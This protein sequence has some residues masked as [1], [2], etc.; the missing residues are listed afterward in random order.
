MSEYKPTFFDRHGPD[1]KHHLVAFGYGFMIFGLVAGVLMLEAGLHW[2]VFPVALAAGFAGGGL[3]LMLGT[4]TGR[5]WEHFMMSGASTPYVEQYSY[6]QALVMK[7]QVDEALASFEHVIAARP[8]AVGARIKAAELYL[9]ERRNPE[10]A[11]QLFREAQRTPSITSG[12]DVYV[13]NRLVDL[14]IG[15]LG[16]PG[17]ALVELRHL[18]ERHPGTGAA[19]NARLAIGELKGRMDIRSS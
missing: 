3:G 14:L 5:V 16:D 15:P 9:S 19:S 2:W 7:G 6:E 11:A 17:R 13:T 4:G 12:E 10:R 8:D 1:A 18:I